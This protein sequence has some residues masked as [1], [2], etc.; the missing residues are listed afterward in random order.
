MTD[1]QFDED[2][3]YQRPIQVAQKPF[4]VQ[5]VPAT[6]AEYV[7]LGIACFGILFSLFMLF[8]SRSVPKP[9]VPS[10]IG[11]PVSSTP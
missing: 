4:F 3:E 2:Q 1:I 5:L 8:S 7:L 9:V 10:I 11:F 6:K